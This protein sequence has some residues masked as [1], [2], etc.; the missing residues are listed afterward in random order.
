MWS[1]A[2]RHH[3]RNQLLGE[4]SD[5]LIRLM[6]HKS[7]GTEPEPNLS[8]AARIAAELGWIENPS[9]RL[10]DEGRLASDSCREYSFW[11]DRQK[12]LPFEGAAPHLTADYFINRNVVEI[13]SG[14]GANLLSLSA[15][16]AEVCG[17]E[18]VADYREMGELFAEREG[19]PTMDV[20]DGKGENLPFADDQVDTVLC[21]STHQYFDIHAAL[22][23][24][25]RIL[26]PGGELIIVGGT[27][28]VYGPEAAIELLGGLSRAKAYVI[29]MVN[30][31]SYMVAGK[32]I[33]ASRNEFSTSRPIYPSKRA[34]QRW[35]SAAG[36]GEITPPCRV[37][38][39]TCFH[40]CAELEVRQQ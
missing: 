14:M 3:I 11:L 27:L 19:L 36:M 12:A 2:Q 4:G 40:Y 13:G 34:M 37:E 35:L 28:G 29:T 8:D 24:I 26:R 25:A 9:G 22:H 18:P 6:L 10:T 1:E 15:A 23:E 16:G 30:T 20:R 38:G 5:N 7:L 33:L 21:V 17:I 32:R 39:E 31:V